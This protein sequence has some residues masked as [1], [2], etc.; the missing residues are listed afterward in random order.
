MAEPVTP[1]RI[2]V[3]GRSLHYIAGGSGAEAFVFVHGFG[4]DHTTWMLTLPAFLSRGRVFALDLPGHGRSDVDVGDGSVGTFATLLAGFL[5]AIGVARAHLVGHS[6]GGAIATELAL[7][8]PA[9]VASLG[10]IAPA[11]FGPTINRDFVTHFPELGDRVAARALVELLVTNPRLISDQMIGD[12]LA[13][14]GRPGVRDALRAIVAA[15]FPAGEQSVNYRDR[16]AGLGLPVK[17]VWGAEDRILAV[18]EPVGP[19]FPVEVVQKA[20]HLAQLEAATRVN[21]L[22][23]PPAP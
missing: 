9:N 8:H 18:A 7:A 23:A 21:R 1:K 14:L 2:S 3:I 16:I 17:M 22:I 4:A 12:L 19:Q 10:L 15:T 13:Y 20:G 5:D 11:G 6:L